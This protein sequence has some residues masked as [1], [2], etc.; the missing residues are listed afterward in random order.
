MTVCV[1]TSSPGPWFNKKMSSYQYRKSHCGD[2]T[3][4]R[5]S[6]LHNGFPIP[7]RR[8]YAPAH[9]AKALDSHQSQTKIFWSLHRQMTSLQPRA[10]KQSKRTLRHLLLR[11]SQHRTARMLCP[12]VRI[13][14]DYSR[15][16]HHNHHLA[17][18]A[19]PCPRTPGWSTTSTQKTKEASPVKA[20]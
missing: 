7:V 14:R 6:Y 17:S 4:V 18:R 15:H 19:P 9:Q 20:P 12:Q 2:N 3:V 16:P 11:G 10:S 1:S 5:L 8:L 13:H